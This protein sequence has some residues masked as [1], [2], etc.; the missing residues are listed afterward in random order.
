MRAVVEAHVL[1]GGGA[2]LV[3]FLLTAIPV[4]HVDA[5]AVARVKDG[6]ALHMQLGL[7]LALHADAE[8][9]FCR[10]HSLDPDLCAALVLVAELDAALVGAVAEGIGANRSNTVPFLPILLLLVGLLLFTVANTISR[11]FAA[12]V[13]EEG[14]RSKE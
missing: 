1:E 12:V 7:W 9:A 14:V 2:E 8:A 3:I 4:A 5:V 10:E 13:Q 11:R 6:V